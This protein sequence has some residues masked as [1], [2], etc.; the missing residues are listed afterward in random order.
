MCSLVDEKA[1]PMML[2]EIVRRIW[3]YHMDRMNPADIPRLGA[4]YCWVHC[5]AL[6]VK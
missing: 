3:D 1:E 2:G 5:S 6:R 4:L